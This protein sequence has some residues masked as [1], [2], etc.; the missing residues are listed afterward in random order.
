[1][2]PCSKE[3]GQERKGRSCDWKYFSCDEKSGT[4][5]RFQESGG[6]ELMVSGPPPG[7]SWQL[8]AEGDGL[9]HKQG[10]QGSS[11]PLSFHLPLPTWL[12]M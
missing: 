11:G 8:P 5:Q 1:M 3:D 10:R 6:G 9:V 7:T 2:G 12:W 4:S